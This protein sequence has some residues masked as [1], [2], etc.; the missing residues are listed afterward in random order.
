MHSL[1]LYVPFEKATHDCVSFHSMAAA[2]AQSALPHRSRQ[3]SHS[4]SQTSWVQHAAAVSQEIN[5]PS[6]PSGGQG[7]AL[8]RVMLPVSGLASWVVVCAGSL[9]CLAILGINVQPLLTV[10]GVSTVLV[11]LSAQSVLANLI[12]GINLVSASLLCF[13]P[14]F[15]ACTES[16]HVIVQIFAHQCWTMS[17]NQLAEGS[18]TCSWP[19]TA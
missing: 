15:C 8:E 18:I 6:N 10:G 4:S 11:G 14:R 1:T 19:R 17:Y 7:R 9:M 3:A 2:F 12:S 5:D 13:V 16:K